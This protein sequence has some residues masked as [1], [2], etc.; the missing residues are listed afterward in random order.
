[1]DYSAINRAGADAASPQCQD[2][3]GDARTAHP[4]PRDRARSRGIGAIIAPDDDLAEIEDQIRERLEGFAVAF[5]GEPN[6]G[7]RDQDNWR[8][9]TNNGQSLCMRGPK[10]I[11]DAQ[12]L[13]AASRQLAGTV[14]ETYLT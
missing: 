13:W 5:L 8:W 6:D 14:A 4:R 7:S 10:R 3:A 11:D 9:G 1:M 12:R 2:L